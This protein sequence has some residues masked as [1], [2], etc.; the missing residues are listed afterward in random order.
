MLNFLF[1]TLNS[2]AVNNFYVGKIIIF[3]M[4]SR[5]S[6]FTCHEIICVNFHT[7]IVKNE[8]DHD[9]CNGKLNNCVPCN[10]YIC[11]IFG[12]EW[13]ISFFARKMILHIEIKLWGF[14]QYH[15]SWLKIIWNACSKTDLPI[16]TRIINLV[17]YFLS[18]LCF[19]FH[20]SCR[21]Q[22]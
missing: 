17:S 13:I 1:N 6:N 19:L 22:P 5:R 8:C 3:R 18:Y 9:L 16:F 20:P 12:L 21:V 2:R 15:S 14:Y 4:R 7:F 11:S 10:I